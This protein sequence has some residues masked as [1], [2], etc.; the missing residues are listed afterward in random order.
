MSDSLDEAREVISELVNN[1][2][3]PAQLVGD[4]SMT[5]LMTLV[6]SIVDDA[7]KSN[8]TDFAADDGEE[9][10]RSLIENVALTVGVICIHATLQTQGEG[11]EDEPDVLI[12]LPEGAAADFVAALIRNRGVTFKLEMT[13]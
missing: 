1:Q 9:Q 2:Q 12:P 3:L 6:A 4:I 7:I 11:S 5:D 10:M 13:N 8:L